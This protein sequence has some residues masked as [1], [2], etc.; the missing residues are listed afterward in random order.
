MYCTIIVSANVSSLPLYI[1]W[2]HIGCVLC[3]SEMG[4]VMYPGAWL[5]E[6]S[7]KGIGNNLLEYLPLKGFFGCEVAISIILKFAHKYTCLLDV[8]FQMWKR[9]I[10][11]KNAEM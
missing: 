2:L 10:I 3:S 6:H 11:S 5:W 9:S 8:T 4:N 7:K 1:N